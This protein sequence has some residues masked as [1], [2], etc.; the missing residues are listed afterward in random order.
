MKKPFFKLQIDKNGELVNP[1]SREQKD[2]KD[3]PSASGKGEQTA[4]SLGELVIREGEVD[5]QDDRRPAPMKQ[6]ADKKSEPQ[7]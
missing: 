1:L 7:T 3:A 4:F 5:F 6:G 2:K